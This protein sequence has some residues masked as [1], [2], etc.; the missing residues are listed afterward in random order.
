MGRRFV[1]LALL[2]AFFLCGA[3][4]WLLPARAAD[5]PAAAGEQSLHQIM[6]QL[7]QNFRSLRRSAMKAEE[8]AQTH[9]TLQKMEMLVLQAKSR[10]PKQARELEP[11][12]RAKLVHAYQL[13]MITLLEKLVAAERAVLEARHDAVAELVKEIYTVQRDAHREFRIED[14]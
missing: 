12:E 1:S 2:S 6:E 10:E 13:Q 7:G 14:E 3:G 11:A 5:P 9:E 8:A 4:V